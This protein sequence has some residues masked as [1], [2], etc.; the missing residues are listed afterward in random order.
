MLR[1]PKDEID[2]KHKRRNFDMPI[3][4]ETPVNP[5]LAHYRASRQRLHAR[6]DAKLAHQAAAIADKLVPKVQQVPTVVA[7]DNP[8]GK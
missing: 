3:K 6:E 5:V 8:D 4:K 2:K 7:G 1:S